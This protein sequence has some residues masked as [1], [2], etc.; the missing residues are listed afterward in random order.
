MATLQQTAPIHAAPASPIPTSRFDG[1][2]GPRI[3]GPRG[4]RFVDLQSVGV[5]FM[6]CALAS[7]GLAGRV[8]GQGGDADAVLKEFAANLV[9]SARLVPA[10]VIGVTHAQERGYALLYVG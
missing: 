1:S 8:A 5:R 4:G 6:V 7:R 2:T 3:I 10:G 9:P